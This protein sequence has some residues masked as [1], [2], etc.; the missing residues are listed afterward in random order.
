MRISVLS[1]APEAFSGFRET[2]VISRAEG[3]GAITF[4]CIDIRD[5]A[6]GSFRKIDDSPYG[7][8]RGMILRVDTVFRALE[9][10]RGPGSRVVMLSPKGQQ[11]TQKKARE[12]SKLD[13]LVLLCGHY[14]GFDAR[15][16][17]YVDEEISIGDYILTGGE[18][19]AMIVCDSVVRLLDGSL[20]EGSADDESFETGLLEYPQ[21]THPFEFNGDKVPEIL[22]SG[23]HEA[24]DRWR[25]EKALEETKRLRPDLLERK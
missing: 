5:Y 24:I 22:L 12:Y 17:R 8:G 9:A 25:R 4:E 23:N 18:L 2:P 15:I 16:S 10:V 3:R 1:I 19:P 13:H 14:E 7:G 21:Y 20:R 11:F 6:E